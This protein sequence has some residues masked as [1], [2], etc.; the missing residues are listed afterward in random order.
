MAKL[1]NKEKEWVDAR[2]RYALTH[3]Q[4][5]MGREL[6]ILPR[7]LAKQTDVPAY[8]EQL[9]LERFGRTE[10]AIVVTVENRAR[11]EQRDNAMEKLAQKK[12]GPKPKEPEPPPPA[13]KPRKKNRPHVSIPR[14]PRKGKS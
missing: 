5:Q 4:V 3:A 13:P 9:Y 12:L 8:L 14:P 7:S 11:Q 2:Q 6:E 10:P 1:N